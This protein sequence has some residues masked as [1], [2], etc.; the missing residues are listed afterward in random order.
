[1]S[2]PHRH[3]HPIPLKRGSYDRKADE[4]AI[5]AR[6]EQHR[7]ALVLWAVRR[8]CYRIAYRWSA[9]QDQPPMNNRA[10]HSGARATSLKCPV[11]RGSQAQ[12]GETGASGLQSQQDSMS[13]CVKVVL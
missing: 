12:W 3:Y 7:D 1:M 8:R 2:R 6:K 4:A 10:I 11:T 9:Q 5:K 13:H